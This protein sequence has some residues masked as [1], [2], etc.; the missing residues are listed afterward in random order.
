MDT[1]QTT[2]NRLG[3]PGYVVSMLTH[4]DY[5]AG[6]SDI[7]VTSLIQPPQVA[8]LRRHHKDN[9]AHDVAD[10]VWQFVGRGIHALMEKWANENVVAEERLFDEVLGWKVSG[11]IDVQHYVDDGIEIFDYKFTSAR[12]ILSHHIEWEKQL[13]LYRLLIERVKKTPVLSLN[14][15]AIIRDWDRHRAA[16]DPDYPQAAVLNIE[17]PMW[18]LA[19]SAR[20]MEERVALHQQAERDYQWGNPLPHCTPAERWNRNEKWAVT[21]WQMKRA[22]RVVSSKSEAEEIARDLTNSTGTLHVVDR[23]PGSMVRCEGNFC[24]VAEFCEQLREEKEQLIAIE[25][26]ESMLIR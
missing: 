9:I 19:E 1:A 18:S 5:D 16:Q 8:T 22:A 4:E 15:V 10:T 25:V 7:T 17:L 26:A 14:I 20:F 21:K 24:G 6:D 3:L 11:Q 23:R 13:N 2:K 12:S